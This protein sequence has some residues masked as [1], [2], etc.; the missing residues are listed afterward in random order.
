MAGQRGR[1]EC[2]IDVILMSGSHGKNLDLAACYFLPTVPFL[3][4]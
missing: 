2:Q 4:K 3:L 1:K